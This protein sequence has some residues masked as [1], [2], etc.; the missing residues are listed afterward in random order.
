MIAIQPHGT[1][2]RE[3]NVAAE[4]EVPEVFD[5]LTELLTVVFGVRVPL[6]A[7][8]EPYPDPRTA[9]V[10]VHERVPVLPSADVTVT[11]ALFCPAVLYVLT[12]ED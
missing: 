11:I 5:V 3:N 8:D 4:S 2:W 7:I 6:Y 10:F 12:T 1:F 9:R